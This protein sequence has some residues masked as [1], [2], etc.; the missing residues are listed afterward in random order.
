MTVFN[1]YSSFADK[2]LNVAN[3]V[4]SKTSENRIGFGSLFQQA[5]QGHKLIEGSSESICVGKR[6]KIVNISQYERMNIKSSAIYLVSGMGLLLT[7]RDSDAAPNIALVLKNQL[8][9]IKTEH[10]N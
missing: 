7:K 5:D 2:S 9:Q 4:S 6:W 10:P 8:V 3:T 1:N